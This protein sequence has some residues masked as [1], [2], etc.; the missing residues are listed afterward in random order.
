LRQ[1]TGVSVSTAECVR[2]LA[3]PLMLYLHQEAPKR[4][5]RSR[6]R[7]LKQLQYLLGASVRRIY[8]DHE[9]GH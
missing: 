6:E 1:L 5:R 7:G 8:A 9:E 2:K 3:T 4:H